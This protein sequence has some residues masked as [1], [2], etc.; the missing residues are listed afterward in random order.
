MSNQKPRQIS[1]DYLID[2]ISVFASDDGRVCLKGSMEG[3]R[4]YFPMTPSV[5]RELASGLE[6]FGVAMEARCAA[7]KGA[8]PA[9][10]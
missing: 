6:Y 5:A 2:N 7:M 9:P 8:P 3:H 1:K 4:V 10:T